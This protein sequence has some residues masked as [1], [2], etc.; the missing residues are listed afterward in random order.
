LENLS[1]A[2]VEGLVLVSVGFLA[3]VGRELVGDLGHGADVVFAQRFECVV[4]GANA[5]EEGLDVREWSGEIRR[6]IG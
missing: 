6:G 1:V 4:A 2:D 3:A 5:S